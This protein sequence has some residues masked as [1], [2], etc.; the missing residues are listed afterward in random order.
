MQRSSPHALHRRRTRPTPTVDLAAARIGE[1]LR[2]RLWLDQPD[3][4]LA[5]VRSY[6]AERLE[7]LYPIDYHVYRRR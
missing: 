6:V 4:D 2:L 3:L 7:R 1:L 5:T